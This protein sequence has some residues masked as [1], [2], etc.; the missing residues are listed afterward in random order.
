MKSMIR[1]FATLGIISSTCFMG[2]GQWQKVNALPEEEIQKKLWMPVFIVT[3]ENGE[4]LSVPVENNQQITSVFLSPQ[5]AVDFRDS[6]TQAQPDLGN[7]QVVGTSMAEIYN[8]DTKEQNLQNFIFKYIPIP[9]QIAST[10]LFLCQHSSQECPAENVQFVETLRQQ[11]NTEN[12]TL[13]EEQLNGLTRITSIFDGVPLF[14]ITD[15]DGNYLP[16]SLTNDNREMIPFFFELEQ[17]NVVFSEVME[18]YPDRAD[19]IGIEITTLENVI[20][21]I[22]TEDTPQVRQFEI[23]PTRETFQ[24]IQSQSNNPNPNNPSNP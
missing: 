24:L 16:V 10:F 5:A 21:R 8:L 23:V 13:S 6:R 17:L 18:K 19:S 11:L 22:E 15:G 4:L 3:T 9:Q 12:P 20:K 14:V 1:F 2:L 7:L